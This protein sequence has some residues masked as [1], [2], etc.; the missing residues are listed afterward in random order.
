MSSGNIITGLY[1]IFQF[2]NENRILPNAGHTGEIP[3]QW[4]T[5]L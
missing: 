4:L 5:L 3:V 2:D 1:F